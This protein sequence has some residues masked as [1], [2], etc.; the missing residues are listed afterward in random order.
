MGKKRLSIKELEAILLGEDTTRGA[1]IL[2]DGTIV[3]TPPTPPCACS[4]KDATIDVMRAA[5]VAKNLDIGVAS[6]TIREQRAT[7]ERLEY[8]RDELDELERT[9]ERL[10]KER[11]HWKGSQVATM[12]LLN[13]E[14]EAHEETQATL[15]AVRGRL[16]EAWED[17]DGIVFLEFVDALLALLDA[18]PKGER[19]DA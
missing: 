8:V 7:I 1:N 10:R 9:N 15:D 6:D 18:P 3:E 17:P 16:K 14:D 19:P 4:A 12:S 13:A 11:D 5:I 2:P